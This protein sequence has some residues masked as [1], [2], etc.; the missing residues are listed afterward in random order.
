MARQDVPG[1]K[2]I[3]APF[4]NRRFTSFLFCLLLSVLFWFLHAL[5]KEYR[6]VIRV[7]VKYQHLPDHGLIAVDMPDS[8][9][10]IVSGSG[11]TVFA[12][13]WVNL[14]DP[15]ELDVSRA[16]S[17]GNGDYALPTISHSDRLEGAIG[18]GLHVLNV[19]PDTLFLNFAGRVTKKIPVR[20]RISVGCAPG[21]RLGDSIKTVP[22]YVLVSGAEALVDK[23]SYV[24]TE[25]KAF[26]NL[27]HS[28]TGTIRLVLP[29]AFSQLQLSVNEVQLNVPV[30]QYTEQRISIPVETINVPPSVVLKTIPDKVDMV[31]QVTLEDYASIRA[32]MFRVVA[33]YSKA[34]PKTGDIPVSVQRQPLNI[35]NLRT[36]PVRVEYIIRK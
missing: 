10:A 19:M 5:S 20:T 28:L 3:T 35:R 33:D 13:K 36:D 8:V 11:F 1:N 14:V 7:P 23:I 2:T 27:D 31:F 29:A 32:D 21:F 15:L 22:S 12:Y 24:E 30:G 6:I 25:Q 4:R 9:D 34:D 17:L 18:N 26:M 16:R